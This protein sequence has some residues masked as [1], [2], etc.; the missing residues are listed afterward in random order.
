V[1]NSSY[2]STLSLLTSTSLHGI[3]T[4]AERIALVTSSFVSACK[5]S[6]NQANNSCLREQVL[7]D[8]Y[9]GFGTDSPRIYQ[10]LEEIWE[11][12]SVPGPSC[13]ASVVCTL[14]HNRRWATALH[15]CSSVFSRLFWETSFVGIG[16]VSIHSKDSVS[17][18]PRKTSALRCVFGLCSTFWLA[19]CI[20]KQHVHCSGLC[21]S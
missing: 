5:L 16:E 1:Q 13:T 9:C 10:D 8:V 12:D 15:H 6:I 19:S 3:R 18:K 14:F 21:V 20:T 7:E 11:V 2:W 17:R 4:Q